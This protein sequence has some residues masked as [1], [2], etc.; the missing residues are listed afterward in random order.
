MSL[1]ALVMSRSHA[2]IRV[3]ISAFAELGIEYQISSSA[4]EAAD[5]LAHSYHSALIVDFDLPHSVQIAQAVRATPTRR[6]VIFGMIGAGTSI[7][8]AFL[9]GSNFVLYKPLDLLQVLHS[10]RAA[11]G[12]MRSGHMQPS[13]QQRSAVACL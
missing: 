1:N 6:P 2:S 12:F 9:A 5:V 7:E 13:P 3:L 11:Q 8:S 10:L 4:S